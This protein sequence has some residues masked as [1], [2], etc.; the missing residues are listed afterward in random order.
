MKT[1]TL[2]VAFV[3]MACG[4][5]AAEGKPAPPAEQAL[6]SAARL[7]SAARET[8][9][10]SGCAEAAPAY[11]V[12]AAMGEGQEPAQHELGECLLLI[13]GASAAETALFRQEALFWLA[14]AAYAGN[15]R[16]QRALAVHYGSIRAPEAAAEALKWALVYE[17]NGDANVYGFKSLP[18]TFTPGLRKD[19][20]TEGTSKAEAFAASFKPV[21]LAK[22][23]PPA[24]EKKG[25]G[26]PFGREEERPQG[27][28][29][30][31]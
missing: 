26:A 23:A 3:I 7:L 21:M 13:D 20:G 15:A 1:E 8:R 31:R 22:F 2:V 29:R 6:A 28:E 25:D 27:G 9:E 16:A 14:R 4:A 11:R 10:R 18:P 24:P 17:R 19:L 12:V 30:R 5:A